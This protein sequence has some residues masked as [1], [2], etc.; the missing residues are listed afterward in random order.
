MPTERRYLKAVVNGHIFKDLK[1]SEEGFVLDGQKYN[2][3]V[4]RLP[5]GR[6]HIILDGRNQ[7]AEILE[8]D[9]NKKTFRIKFTSGIYEILLLDQFDDLLQKL[10]MAAISNTSVKSI[11]APM[12]G[13][14]LKIPVKSGDTVEK[15][16]ALVILKAMKMENIIKSPAKSLI[17]KVLVSEGQAVEKNQDLILF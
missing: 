10:G 11:K 7:V 17:Q 14:I 16:D 5:D 8:A 13:M 15:G 2:W 4:R 12:P 6:Y 1:V 3:D 9:H